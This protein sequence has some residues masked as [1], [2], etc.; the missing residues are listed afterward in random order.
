MFDGMFMFGGLLI[1]RASIPRPWLWV[2]MLNPVP[3]ALNA[4]GVDQ[5]AC[6]EEDESTLSGTCAPFPVTRGDGSVSHESAAQYASAY[7]SSS[8][9]DIWPQV[10]WLVLSIAVVRV[11]CLATVHAQAM[12]RTRK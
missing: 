5:F 11:L 6:R 8:V 4:I 10:G 1:D 2:Y 12:Q 7:L 9:D 3:K